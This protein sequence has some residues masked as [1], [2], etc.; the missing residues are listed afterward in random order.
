LADLVALDAA[1]AILTFFLKRCGQRKTGQIHN[2]AL[3]LINIAR[4]WAKV[5]PEQLE[6]LQKLRR[7]PDRQ[8]PGA[9]PAVRG[10]GEYWKAGAAIR[11][12]RRRG[13][14]AGSGRDHRGPQDADRAG[15]RHPA[16]VPD[17]G[18]E[19]GGP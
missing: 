6:Q 18:E 12:V 5:P 10:R 11:A 14:P 4:Y 7:R 9:A 1:K 17:P 15:A 19:P 13:S 2:F 3:L 8:E 16:G